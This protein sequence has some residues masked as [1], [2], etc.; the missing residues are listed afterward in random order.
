MLDLKKKMMGEQLGEDELAAKKKAVLALKDKLG[1]DLEGRL[2]A[3]KKVTVAAPSQ[4]GLKKGLEVAEEAVEGEEM[5]GMEEADPVLEACKE[6][7]VDEIQSLIEKLEELKA[8]KMAN[9]SEP[10]LEG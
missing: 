8:E 7:G 4:E 2:G 6:K 9:V 1:G 5:E 3:L 10:S